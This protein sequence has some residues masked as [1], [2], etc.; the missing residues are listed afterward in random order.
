MQLF[1]VYK[2]ALLEDCATLAE[3]LHK[4]FLAE[5]LKAFVHTE[6]TSAEF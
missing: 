3:T 5:L 6:L 1:S 4:R 2:M